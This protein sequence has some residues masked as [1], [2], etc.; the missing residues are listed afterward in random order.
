[1][2]SISKRPT[3]K[4]F[5]IVLAGVLA[6]LQCR[7]FSQTFENPVIIIDHGAFSD[8]FIDVEVNPADATVDMVYLTKPGTKYHLLYVKLFSDGTTWRSVD[9]AEFSSAF[10]PYAAVTEHDGRVFAIGVTDDGE[11][12]F[13]MSEDGGANFSSYAPGRLMKRADIYANDFACHL[14]YIDQNNR[15]AYG[16]FDPI[17][18]TWLFPF[19]FGD[20][21]V[22]AMKPSISEGGGKLFAIYQAADTLHY[23]RNSIANGNN[24]SSANIIPNSKLIESNLQERPQLGPKSATSSQKVYAAW[25]GYT[26]QNNSC[27]PD[28]RTSRKLFAE[29]AWP[30]DPRAWLGDPSAYGFAGNSIGMHTVSWFPLAVDTYRLEYRRWRDGLEFPEDL[31]Y[32][33]ENCCDLIYA[34]RIVDAGAHALGAYAIYGNYSERDDPQIEFRREAFSR[35]APPAGLYVVA[36]S[37]NSFD[38]DCLNDGTTVAHVTTANHDH[39]PQNCPVDGSQDLAIV[40]EGAATLHPLLKWQR[41]NYSHDVDSYIIWRHVIPESPGTEW[42]PIDSVSSTV[43]SYLDT[44]MAVLPFSWSLVEYRVAAKSPSRL[45]SDFSNTVSIWATPLGKR[46]G[47]VLNT[48]ALEFELLQNYPN[49]FNPSTSISFQIPQD[50]VVTLR[51]F[52]LLGTEVATLANEFRRAGRYNAVFDASR[53]ASG[54]YIYKLQSGNFTDIKRMLLVK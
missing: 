42:Q 46:R 22:L 44:R 53:L 26:T 18:K 17:G 27:C 45:Y 30:A 12:R 33:A 40:I 8:W 5:F 11:S 52:D 41:N 48:E 29:P 54:V 21:L 32:I 4:L 7:V 9:L 35:P 34:P 15:L 23:E 37:S 1:M 19:T 6:S 49:P 38:L 25:A 2:K 39:L 14:M 16:R 51:V 10:P 3:R 24:W 31:I 50:G 13:S 47:E 43:T 20:Q 36:S 28:V